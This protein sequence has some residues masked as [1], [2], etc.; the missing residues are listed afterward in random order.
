MD[1]SKTLL[2]DYAMP[3]EPPAMHP[4]VASQEGRFIIFGKD[5][6]LLEQS[7]RLG[8]LDGCLEDEE[9]R[10]E[11]I[12]FDVE[13]ADALLR[14]LAQLGISHRTLFPDLTG[15][16][17]FVRWKHFHKVTRHEPNRGV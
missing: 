17:A 10:I 9:L 8:R 16:A 6:D 3:I 13:D 14:D 1:D 7:I 5:Q 4:R 12:K 15:L 2:P 11:Q